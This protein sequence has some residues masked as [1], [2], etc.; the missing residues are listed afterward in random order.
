MD[1]EVLHVH[2]HDHRWSL[3]QCVP[4]PVLVTTRRARRLDLP[5]HA[6]L[7]L[8]GLR[9]SYQREFRV[10]LRSVVG[11]IDVRDQ[12]PLHPR[13]SVDTAAD[14]LPSAHDLRSLLCAVDQEGQSRIFESTN[15]DDGRK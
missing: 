8:P 5:S 11:G 3:V 4:V 12:Y 9:R 15:R 10:L 2:G 1:D 13:P 7:Q 14:R 6:P